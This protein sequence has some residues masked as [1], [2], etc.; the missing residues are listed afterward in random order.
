MEPKVTIVCI[1]YN[2]EKYIK[3]AIESFLMQKTNFP[4]EVIISDDCST[5][6]TVGII[7]EYAQKYPN[8]IKPIFRDKNLGVMKNFIDTL[9]QVKSKYA[10]V[11]E[12]DDYF[13]DENKLQIQYDFLEKN[14]QYS[15][16]FHPVKIIYE[17][18]TATEIFPEKKL[19]ESQKEISFTQ[20]LQC[21]YIQTNSIMYRWR[22]GEENIKDFISAD[23]LPGDWYVH[24]LHAQCS[25]IAYLDKVM[26]VYRKHNEGIWWGSNHNPEV[27]H[28]KHGA[29]E[30]YFFYK[31]YKDL[32]TCDENYLNNV[33]L[34][35]VKNLVKILYKYKKFDIL[36]SIE[37][38]EPEIFDLLGNE[39]LQVE[40]TEQRKLK[41][42]RKLFNI[43][44]L[45]SI[46]E[47]IIIVLVLL[48]L[49]VLL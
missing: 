20:L 35:S 15:A 13:S 43:F 24:L 32:T 31:V 25:N 40:Q 14:P 41:K 37:T 44:L 8:L 9:S 3:D 23:I 45:C 16:C 7:K 6:N 27:L 38:N 29:K 34:P 12:G 42:Y 17:N 33:F 19:M 5:D 36:K 2:Q 46:V 26:S 22:F 10:I 47:F 4:F 39:M 49:Y 48:V 28:L 18:S 1:T 21:N 11:N 30:I